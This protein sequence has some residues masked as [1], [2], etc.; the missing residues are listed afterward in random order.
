MY[1]IKGNKSIL[2]GKTKSLHK[3]IHGGIT[4]IGSK[5]PTAL[6]ACLRFLLRLSWCMSAEH[7]SMRKSVEKD[8]ING[9][10]GMFNSLLL[11]MNDAIMQNLHV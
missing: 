8:L 11:I 10:Y 9:V 6:A 2:S 5:S 4:I 1:R 7:G 3:V